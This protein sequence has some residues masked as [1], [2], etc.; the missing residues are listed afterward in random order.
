VSVATDDVETIVT[1]AANLAA[2]AAQLP[3]ESPLLPVLAQAARDLGEA[4]HRSAAAVVGLAMPK[5]DEL[6]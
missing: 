3:D 5:A 1:S 6:R 2:R 4:A